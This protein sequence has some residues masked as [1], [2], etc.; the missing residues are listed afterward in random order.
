MCSC[1]IRISGTDP[2]DAPVVQ[3][4]YLEH[5]TDRLTV[6]RGLKLCRTFLQSGDLG[7][8]YDTEEVPGSDV[9]SDDQLLQYARETG[10]TGYHLC[11][12]CTM[13]PRSN[14]M[15]VVGPDLKVHGLEGLRVVDASVMPRVTS[16]N[17]C[18]ASMMIGEKGADMIIADFSTR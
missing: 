15:T 5:E 10:N 4:N 13:G 17:T 18:A 1:Y 8:L 6:V 2:N 12:T 16:S 7:D 14:P 9:Q 3:P 11:G